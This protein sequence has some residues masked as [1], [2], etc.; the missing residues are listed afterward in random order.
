M[1]ECISAIYTNRTKEA[2]AGELW[3]KIKTIAGGQ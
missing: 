3:Q 1:P 2:Y